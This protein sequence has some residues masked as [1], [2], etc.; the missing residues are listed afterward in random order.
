MQLEIRSDGSHFLV[1]FIQITL[2][3]LGGIAMY[4][5]IDQ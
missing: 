4:Q 5:L 1:Q 2:L 3:R